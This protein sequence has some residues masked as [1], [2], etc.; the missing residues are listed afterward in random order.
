MRN[1][2]LKPTDLIW[3]TLGT[4]TY[5]AISLL[6][7]I[8]VIRISGKTEGGIFSFGFSTLA[9]LTF[10]ITYFGIRPM[11]IVDIKYKYSPSD[12]I[13]FGKMMGLISLII[14]SAFVIYRYFIGNYTITKV[15][16]L[17][18]LIIHGI[19]DGFADYY[20][21]EYQRVNKLSFC[22]QSLFFRIVTFAIT[23]IVSLEFT[24]NLLLSEIIAIVVELIMFYFLNIIRSKNLFKTAKSNDENNKF[25]NLFLDAFPL[26]L[27]TFLDMYIFSSAKFAID[28]S[29][30]DVASGF[31]NLIFMPTN[32]IYLLMTLF[33]KPILT[34]LSNA[35]HTDKKEYNKLLNKSMLFALLIC[36]L[37]IIMLYILGKYY[38]NIINLITT[39][40]YVEFKDMAFKLLFVVFLGG[41]LYTL[42][43]PIYFSIII[44]NKQKYLFYSYSVVAIITLILSNRFVILYGIMG[45]AY[46]FCFSMFLIL[47][48][49][50]IVKLI[51][52]IVS[53]E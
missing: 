15:Q 1:D 22:G 32:A 43:T 45:A 5:A 37:S 10:I 42:S 41:C 36:A 47:I 20:E 9:R 13:K 39:N 48:S 38:I 12:Y 6:I 19:I 21:C 8:F 18:L 27:I 28:K 30:G 29:I 3:N 46:S 17:Y 26:F 7:S 40:N 50:F 2:N 31:F 52:K 51:I 25:F 4:C 49:I 16:I 35:Y 33:M 53:N 44:E 11:H 24:K 34:P 14:G 23:L